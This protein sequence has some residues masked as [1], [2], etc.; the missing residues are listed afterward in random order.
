MMIL[1]KCPPC[2][3]FQIYVR[4]RLVCV[5]SP[6]SQLQRLLQTS[7]IE[8]ASQK[9][10]Q[11]PLTDAVC[12]QKLPPRRGEGRSSNSGVPLHN[13]EPGTEHFKSCFH[14]KK[15]Q[16]LRILTVSIFFFF[17]FLRAV[18]SVFSGLFFG[19]LAVAGCCCCCFC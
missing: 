16:I 7:S 8:T 4:K 9:T 15:S 17:F 13:R 10:A 14:L 18:L 1:Q 19:L 11:S 6:P 12:A 2:F 5:V 3:P